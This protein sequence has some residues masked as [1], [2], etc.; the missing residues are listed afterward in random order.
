MDPL[1]KLFQ[2]TEEEK[3]IVDP[4]DLAHR[5]RGRGRTVARRGWREG[6]AGLL[7][8]GVFGAFALK[9]GSWL[10]A[11]GPLLCIGGVGVALGVLLVAQ[12]R[13]PQPDPKAPTEVFL[14]RYRDALRYQALL[15]RRAPLWYLG[16]LVPGVAY[17]LVFAAW[18]AGGQAWIGVGVAGAAVFGVFCAIAW[19]NLRA[20]AALE[21]EAEALG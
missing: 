6:L 17:I 3:M 2:S 19:L 12:G 5:A 15:L 8:C 10:A 9:A 4:Q 11:L 7:A 16:P 14:A 13:A 20:A 21:A 1:Q 18:R